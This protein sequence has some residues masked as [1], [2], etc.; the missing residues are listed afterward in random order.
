MYNESFHFTKS[1]LKL[2][3]VGFSKF[4]QDIAPDLHRILL[5]YIN[6]EGII[7]TIF[8]YM[9]VFDAIL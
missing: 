6:F 1:R 7:N 4:F 5:N 8:N 3:T 2:T 9:T